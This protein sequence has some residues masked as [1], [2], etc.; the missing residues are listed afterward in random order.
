MT[1]Q[2]QQSLFAHKLALLI[3]EAF[4]L[5]YEVTFGDF[6]RDQ[7]CPYGHEKSLHKK[8][9]A[10]DLNLFKDG[11]YLTGEAG[12]TELHDIWDSMGG[13]KR[14]PHDLNHYSLPYQGMR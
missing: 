7:R 4:G 2:K 12:H 14:I 11:R 1:L 6:Y 5:G 8:R 10:A 9:L 3:I 13:A